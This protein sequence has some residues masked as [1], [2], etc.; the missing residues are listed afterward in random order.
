MKDFLSFVRR[1][2]DLLKNLR[3]IT[4][5]G[6]I[7]A[8][9]SGVGTPTSATELPRPVTPE[10]TSP[11]IVDRSRKAA[12][13]VLQLPGTMGFMRAEHRSHRSHSSH[14]SH[15]SGSGGGA[16]APAPAPTPAPAPPRTPP[17]REAPGTASAV[18][19]TTPASLANAVA[20]EVVGINIDTR[21][22]TLRAT[23]TST[24]R[25]TFTYRD[26]SKFQATL[27]VTFRFD[28]FADAN[29]GRLPISTGDKV[30]V[31]WRT[32]PDGKTQIIST[33]QRK[34]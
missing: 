12:K 3:R 32:S 30:E 10:A 6:L 25:R 18:D 11:T 15:F 33:V 4:V 21:T 20:G 2:K 5:G 31:Q 8:A 14:R 19:L 22:I 23:P 7:A 13:L 29:G 28:D 9:G 34:P 17:V 1:P 24:T 16:S 26:D 27:G